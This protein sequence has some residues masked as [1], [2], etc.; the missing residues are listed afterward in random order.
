MIDR[1]SEDIDLNVETETSARPTERQ[2][3]K[4]KAN[5]VSIIDDLGFTL[6]NPDDVR[7]RRDYNRY[8]IDYPS[9]FTA[10]Y[11]KEH[12]V[13]ETAVYIRAYPCQKMMAT[14]IIYDYLHDNGYA[15]IIEQY[16]L[17]QFAV[18]V[19]IAERT[20]IDKLYALG[21]YY[22]CDS[23]RE[24]SRHIYDIYKLLTVVELNDALKQLAK[25]VFEERKN[26][27]NCHSAKDGIDMGALL[28]EIIDKDVYK[29]DSK[30]LPQK[31][32][33]IK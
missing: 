27:V 22:L 5:I 16:Q 18:K 30:R 33:L 21:D 1:F 29:N 23:V 25:D 20:L 11:L 28:Q 32:F 4:L 12:L 13:V 26:H 17:E 6:A 7:S 9:V 19:Q 3:K 24:H 14:S 15:A 2:R 8:I 31:C 10:N